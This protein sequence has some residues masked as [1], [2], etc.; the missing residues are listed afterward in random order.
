MHVTVEKSEIVKLVSLA[1]K[2]TSAKGSLP[3]LSN[4][5]IDADA[6]SNRVT[7]TGTDLD[8]LAT[9]SVAAKITKPGSCCVR[10]KLLSD[11]VK[12]FNDG[13]V[14]L[15][16]DDDGTLHVSSGKSKFG[17][18]TAPANEFPKMKPLGRDKEIAISG[19]D[20]AKAL[21]KVMSAASRD[22]S[23]P[24]LMAVHFSP[25]K[26][27]HLNLAAT[28]SY[29]LAV[30][31]IKGAGSSLQSLGDVVV[32]LSPLEEVVKNVGEKKDDIYV[33][34]DGNRIQFRVGDNI[35]SSTLVNGQY[36]AYENL[37][38]V[39]ENYTASI[40]PND[41]VPALKR[42]QIMGQGDGSVS[43][44]MAF[45]DDEVTLSSSRLDT[46]SASE[47]VATTF[48]HHT[49][50]GAEAD[51]DEVFSIAFNPGFLAEAASMFGDD[52]ITMTIDN[53]IK[54]VSVT[55]KGDPDLQYI[56]MPVRS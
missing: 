40:S 53:P 43:V 21:K 41:I 48:T 38:A 2:G 44:K 47:Q 45:K 30:A 29:R 50:D 25:K 32:P 54:S 7:A 19:K 22:N 9:S 23:R 28:D 18:Q 11:I 27:G 13:A 16:L 10:A 8:F 49:E 15:K 24:I 12:S 33:V 37:L 6:S 20:L 51:P 42:I 5:R 17:V 4:I 46:G 3:I 1:E 39:K 52:D 14:D 26:D 56:L 55:G 34:T 31:K 35:F 36:P